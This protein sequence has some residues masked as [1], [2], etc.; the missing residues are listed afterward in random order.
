MLKFFIEVVLA[1]EVT[2]LFF[3]YISRLFLLSVVGYGCSVKPK[4]K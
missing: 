3:V 2:T 1:E 4:V